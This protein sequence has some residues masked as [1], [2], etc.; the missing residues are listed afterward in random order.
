MTLRS[1]VNQKLISPPAASIIGC[2]RGP[3]FVERKLVRSRTWPWRL[4][5]QSVDVLWW[6]TSTGV[7]YFVVLGDPDIFIY[8]VYFYRSGVCVCGEG[9]WFLIGWNLSRGKKEAI[10]EC[11]RETVR[12]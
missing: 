2:D 11:S 3:R 6:E 8:L 7:K 4:T 5:Q 12:G 9:I 10:R 1:F